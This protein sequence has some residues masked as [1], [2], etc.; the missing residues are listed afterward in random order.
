MDTLRIATLEING[1]SSPTHQEMQDAFDRLHDIDILLM[2]EVTNPFTFGF[3]GYTIQYNIGTPRG[4]TIL[5]RDTIVVN[6]LFR[7]PSGRTIAASLGTL[8]IFKGYAPSRTSKPS[9]REA[10]T[11]NDLP[12]LLS[13][14]LADILL[15]GEFNCILEVS[16][17]TGHGSY[18]RSLATQVQGYTLRDAWQA[19]PDSHAYTHHTTHGTTRID[20]FQ[21]SGHLLTRKSGI[22]TVTTAF[23]DDLAVVL[24]LSWRTPVIRRGRGTWKLN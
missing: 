23:S 5:K 15:G 4:T 16:D 3:Q 18:S 14:Y 17:S 7:I 22:A 12:F 2:Q 21:L 13:S 6:N 11:N 19:R 9:D 1:L 24:C 8:L 20:R 10:F